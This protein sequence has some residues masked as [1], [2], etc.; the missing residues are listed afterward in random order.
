MD[1]TDTDFKTFLE[2]P[3]DFIREKGLMDEFLRFVDK[4]TVGEDAPRPMIMMS[5]PDTGELIARRLPKNV[6]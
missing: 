4:R 5:D 2:T 1:K 6:N 3:F